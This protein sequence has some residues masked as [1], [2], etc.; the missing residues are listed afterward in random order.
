MK[1]AFLGDV[2]FIG[3]YDLII[4]SHSKDR[5]KVMA[6]KLKEFD[7]VVANLESP[8]T[9]QNKSWVCKSMHLRTPIV[10]VELLNYLNVDAVSLA[11][12]HIHDF[13]LKGLEETIEVLEN[14]GVEWFGAKEKYLIK[15]IKDE[16]IC[17]SGF[18]CYSTNGTG[19][20]ERK[21]DIGINA[22]TYDNVMQQ[23]ELDKENS[24]FSILSFHWGTEHTNY[25]N[26]EHISLANK[27]TARKDVIIHGHHP[28]VI[29]G[30]QRYKGSLIA[31]S[32]GNFLFDDCK[33]LNGKFALKQTEDNKKSYVLEVE[34][35]NNAIVDYEFKGFKDE[36][37]GFV[38]FNIS[39][40]I[41]Q[42][43]EALEQ[44]DDEVSYEF[45]RKEQFEKAIQNKFGKHDLKWLMSRLNYYSIGARIS[46]KFRS[47]KYRREM[48]KFLND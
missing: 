20:I 3:K 30:V 2:A 31:Y 47:K 7:Y 39:N 40:E 13:G 12:N 44:L 43:S 45:K 33:S 4:N 34:I 1:I 10:N 11:N 8:L 24:A 5:L 6:E 16:K 21:N 42:I 29:Q 46:A 17:F 26:L 25:P 37:Q 36:D 48:E 19:Y 41:E 23:L 9:E 27:I 18:C 32:L 28:H 14:N 22:L 38:F 35:K 15:E